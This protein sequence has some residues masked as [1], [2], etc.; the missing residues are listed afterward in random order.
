MGKNDKVMV[1][2]KGMTKPYTENCFF[3]VFLSRSP[4]SRMSIL[5]IRGF[6]DPL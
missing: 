6:V 1:E 4:N 5:T 2:H 3:F